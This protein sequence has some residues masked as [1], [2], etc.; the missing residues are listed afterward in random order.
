MVADE[1]LI[2]FLVMILGGFVTPPEY[3]T[4]Q[5]SP[6]GTLNARYAR[7]KISPEEYL[8]MRSE[9]GGGTR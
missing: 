9:L 6:L 4:R 7:G 8:R 2:A 3:V 1:L 5:P